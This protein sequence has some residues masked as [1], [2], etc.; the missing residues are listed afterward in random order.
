MKAHRPNKI[1][2]G[3]KIYKIVD[4]TCE[5]FA[6]SVLFKRGCCYYYLYMGLE[7]PISVSGS[8]SCYDVFELTKVEEIL[9]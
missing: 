1:E 3:N 7:W 8:H 9:L 6:Y 4:R 5:F 2:L